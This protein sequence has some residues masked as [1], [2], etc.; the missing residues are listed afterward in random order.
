MR[1]ASGV[2]KAYMKSQTEKMSVSQGQ[3]FE[4]WS[5]A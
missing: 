2:M 5:D 4:F 3:S 1:M